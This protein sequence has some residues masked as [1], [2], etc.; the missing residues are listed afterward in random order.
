M[1]AAGLTTLGAKAKPLAEAIARF[2]EREGIALQFRKTGK[3]PCAEI[4]VNRQTRKVFFSGTPSD[5][6]IKENVIRDIKQ[7]ARSIGWEQK[8]ENMESVVV[9]SLS[10]LPRLAEPEPKCEPHSVEIR[11][12]KTSTAPRPP[13]IAARNEWIFDRF[14]AGEDKDQ[15]HARLVASGWISLQPQS[16][17]AQYKLTRRQKGYTPG[18]PRPRKVNAAITRTEP[19][20]VQI[21]ASPGIDPL[22]LAIAEAIAPLIRDQLAQQGKALEAMKAKTDKWDAIAE[23]VREG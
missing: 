9:K 16:V 15:I 20:R 2:C 17:Y 12:A 22:V 18:A 4:T 8:E 5:W 14:E 21:T 6:R 1:N 13:N 10:D 11:L 23:L 3:H 7:Q 19:E